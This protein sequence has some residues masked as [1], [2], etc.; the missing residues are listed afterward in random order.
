MSVVASFFPLF[1]LVNGPD[2]GA[3]EDVGHLAHPLVGHPPGETRKKQFRAV[4]SFEN[5]K[6]RMKWEQIGRE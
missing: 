5:I 2:A 4:F 6:V 1:S 3:V